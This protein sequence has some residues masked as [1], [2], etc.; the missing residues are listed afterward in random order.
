MRNKNKI[1]SKNAEMGRNGRLDLYKFLF[2]LCVVLFHFPSNSENSFKLF[3]KGYIAVEFFFIVSGFFFAKTLSSKESN[4]WT[5]ESLSYIWKKYSA[6]FP[7]HIFACVL[8]IVCTAYE[9]N[10]NCEDVIIYTIDNIPGIFLFQI[11][12][13]KYFEFGVHEWYISAML[14]VM[15]ILSPFVIKY[16]EKF[17]SYAAPILS[18]ALF[19]Y[20]SNLSDSIDCVYT[21]N[22][23]MYTGLLRAL[24]DICLGCAVF[25]IY[26]SQVL[27]K[28]SK[29]LLLTFEFLFLI[30]VLL[31]AG[32]AFDAE[33]DYSVPFFM[34]A[35]VSFTVCNKS[36]LPFLN[37]KLTAFLGKF[38]L[39]VYLN[40]NYVRW[41]FSDINWQ[42]KYSSYVLT[43][44]L[45]AIALSLICIFVMD[46]LVKLI[47]KRKR[48]S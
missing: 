1:Q 5:S 41:F 4:N 37:N 22:Y 35:L 48:A 46:A 34:A 9:E 45:S 11:F 42:G 31:Y 6:L 39:A 33:L 19:G 10:F 2:A 29:G 25:S 7:Y 32:G 23:F 3:P 44:L 21:W 17:I 30:A 8:T 26:K 14:A 24:A 28:L 40:H 15:L 13:F 38:S 16:K 36:N 12:G 20:L 18:L 47:K 43:Y 27:E